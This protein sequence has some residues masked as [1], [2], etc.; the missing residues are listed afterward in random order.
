M[1]GIWRLRL[2]LELENY[3]LSYW[4][5][6]RESQRSEGVLTI[7]P[8]ASLQ[9]YAMRRIRYCYTTSQCGRTPLWQELITASASPKLYTCSLSTCSQSLVATIC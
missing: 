2:V 9:E 3:P 1:I 6:I 8:L 5:L 4:R 7:E